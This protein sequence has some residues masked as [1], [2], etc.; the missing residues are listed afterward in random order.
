MSTRCQIG[1]YKQDETDLLNFESLIYRHSDG[2][3]GNESGSRYGVLAD[4]VPF[5]LWWNKVRGISDLEYCA[6]RLLQYLCDKQDGKG[7]E[8]E[9]PHDNRLTG[10]LGHGICK[11]FHSDIEY[12]YAIFPDR[13]EVYNTTTAWLGNLDSKKW[14]KI[15]IIRLDKEQ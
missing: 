2:Y 6:A 9:R 1:F 8:I 11:G 10:I 4:I 3:P 13:L 7:E 14:E 5:L 12:F 15:R